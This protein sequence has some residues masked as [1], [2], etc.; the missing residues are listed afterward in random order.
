CPAAVGQDRNVLTV[1]RATT[2]NAYGLG[3]HFLTPAGVH[4]DL[5]DRVIMPG[6]EMGNA[7]TPFQG[8]FTG[9]AQFPILYAPGGAGESWALFIDRLE[10][11]TGELTGDPWWVTMAGDGIRG[12]LLVG[13]SPVE[14]RRRYMRLVGRPPVPPRKA[15]GLWVSEFGFDDWAELEDKL[16]TLRASRFPVD[17]FMLDLQWF[18]GVFRSPSQMGALAWDTVAFPHPRRGTAGLRKDQ[19]AGLVRIGEPYVDDRQAVFATLAARGHLPSGCDGCGPVVLSAWWGHGSM[20]DW[21]DPAAGDYW[22]DRKRRPLVKM[23]IVGHWTD[24]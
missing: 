12:Y 3:E 19:G 7:L 4:A 10:A 2:R 21:T 6:I 16:R 22:H 15:F 1:A 18:G 11:Q 13:S 24:L 8:G 14:L 5:L 17:G 9:N 23:G 20:L